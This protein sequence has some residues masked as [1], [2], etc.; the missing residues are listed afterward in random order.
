MIPDDCFEDFFQ[1]RHFEVAKNT[2]RLGFPFFFLL[3]S[4]NNAGLRFIEAFTCLSHS[5]TFKNARRG[6]R[7]KTKKTSYAWRHLY[8]CTLNRSW[9]MTKSQHAYIAF[10]TLYNNPGGAVAR[11]NKEDNETSYQWRHLYVCTLWRNL[12][13]RI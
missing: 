13:V 11:Q 12:S 5:H 4:P 3:N 8:V 2:F 7:D 6:V 9:A 1:A 10:T